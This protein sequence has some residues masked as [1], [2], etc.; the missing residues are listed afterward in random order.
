MQ[1]AQ[2]SFS[3]HQTDPHKLLAKTGAG[4]TTEDYRNNQ[5]VFLQG[6]VADSVFFI[7]KGRVKLTVTSEHGKEPKER[8]RDAS[9]RQ[10]TAGEGWRSG[11]MSGETFERKVTT[12]AEREA[13]KTFRQV[14]AERAT[15]DHERAPESR[16]L[17]TISSSPNPQRPRRGCSV[18]DYVL[19]GVVAP[20]AFEGS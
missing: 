13:R 9:A 15:K 7:Q 16:A 4:R 11:G 1:K 19:I 6:E 10:A 17:M 3:P 18:L 2:R 12:P 8:D 14:E 20:R 5:N